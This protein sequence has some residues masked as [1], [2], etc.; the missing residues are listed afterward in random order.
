MNTL[1]VLAKARREASKQPNSTRHRDFISALDREKESLTQKGLPF[2]VDSQRGLMD[3]V[4]RGL[5]HNRRNT[6]EMSG[7]DM[8]SIL[9]P[10]R[11]K[12]TESHAFESERLSSNAG[13]PGRAKEMDPMMFK[14]HNNA[15]NMIVDSCIQEKK[16]FMGDFKNNPLSKESPLRNIAHTRREIDLKHTENERMY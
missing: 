13:S 8:T 10:V 11:L 4:M 6:T 2:A 1:E 16:A 15:V 9:S 5:R 14:R 7:G 3:T 12:R